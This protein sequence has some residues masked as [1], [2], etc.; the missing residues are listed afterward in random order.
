MA[1]LGVVILEILFL[2][3]M[4]ANGPNF[5]RGLGLRLRRL[6]LGAVT[7]AG[8]AV[9]ATLLTATERASHFLLPAVAGSIV[10]AILPLARWFGAASGHTGRAEVSN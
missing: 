8:C 1:T 10:A 4:I 3:P 2:L 7:G 6:E 9:G 5:H